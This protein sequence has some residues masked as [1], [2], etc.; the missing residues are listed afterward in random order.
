MSLVRL[1]FLYKIVCKPKSVLQTLWDALF[2]NLDRIWW[3]VVF[4][5]HEVILY[6]TKMCTIKHEIYFIIVFLFQQ[7]FLQFKIQ[8][9]SGWSVLL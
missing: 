9:W 7:F 8:G 3:S 2:V 6:G 1:N 4:F 5:S